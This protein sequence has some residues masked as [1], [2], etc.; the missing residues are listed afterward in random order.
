MCILFMHLGQSTDGYRLILANNRD[1]LWDRPT[2]TAA[3]RGTARRWIGGFFVPNFLTG[4][5]TVDEYL[6]DVATEHDLYNP[7]H[8]ILVDLRYRQ[9]T[10]QH[11]PT[12]CV[13]TITCSHNTEPITHSYSDGY[14][15]CDNSRDIT[16]PWKKRS[17]G[18]KQ[19]SDIVAAYGSPEHKADLVERLMGLMNDRVRHL[20]DLVLAEQF[21][22]VG[23]STESEFFKQRAAVSVFSPEV[24]YGTRTNT[25]I[26]VDHTGNCSYIERTLKMPVSV[27]KPDYSVVELSFKIKV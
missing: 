27:D 6:A 5:K 3:I 15:S 18:E 2:D 10:N 9:F 11:K 16:K 17:V 22:A 1:E 13:K 26:L 8:L 14:V 21:A 4:E 20:P 25:I 19:F 24:K 23:R 12:L 7:F